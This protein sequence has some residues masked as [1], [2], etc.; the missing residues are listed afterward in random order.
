MGRNNLIKKTKKRVQRNIKHSKIKRTK[1]NIKRSRIQ[2]KRKNFNSLKK[3]QNKRK[4][5]NSLKIK[6]KRMGGNFV[7]DYLCEGH[8][9]FDNLAE[10]VDEFYLVRHGKS[11]ANEGQ[12]DMMRLNG[13]V[14]KNIKGAMEFKGKWDPQ[15]SGFGRSE[16]ETKGLTDPNKLTNSGFVVCSSILLRAQQTAFNMFLRNTQNTLYILP[17]C[18]EERGRAKCHRIMEG[19]ADNCPDSKFWES[20]LN[21]DDVIN[22]DALIRRIDPGHESRYLTF[23]P[24]ISYILDRPTDTAVGGTWLEMNTKVMNPPD[25]R[26]FALTINKLFT[27]MGKIRPIIVT[28]S[29]FIMQIL[30][31]NH[32]QK[33]YNNDIFKFER[34]IKYVHNRWT[35]VYEVQRVT[36]ESIEKEMNRPENSVTGS[37]SPPVI[38]P[39]EPNRRLSHQVS[40]MTQVTPST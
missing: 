23:N 24:D 10:V 25:K 20:L 8:D 34:A 37:S 22:K 21:Q 7:Q 4:R 6:N 40:H 36:T 9:F 15:L 14:V 5:S 1:R 13:K 33:P 28:H 39:G 29:H 32:G 19:Q 38:A 27:V 18:G 11:T 30:G 31:L 16:S 12:E 3:S 35:T 17:D 2:K 26:N